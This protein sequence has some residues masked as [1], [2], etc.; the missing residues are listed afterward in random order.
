MTR[1]PNRIWPA[2][3]SIESLGET[4]FSSNAADAVTLGDG[5]FVGKGVFE[6]AAV[7]NACQAVG[8]GEIFELADAAFLGLEVIGDLGH[9]RMR[10]AC[11]FQNRLGAV[12]LTRRRRL[13]READKLRQFR[14]DRRR[15]VLRFLSGDALQQFFAGESFRSRQVEHAADV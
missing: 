14:D 10:H 1:E 13:F 4:I 11:D 15:R 8:R 12:G 3:T 5:K 9:Q 7:E 6:A 2:L